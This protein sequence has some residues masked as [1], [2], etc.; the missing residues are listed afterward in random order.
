LSCRCAQAT[1]NPSVG[2]VIS[3]NTWLVPAPGWHPRWRFGVPTP[4]RYRGCC[5]RR[6][7]RCYLAR[8]DRV[9]RPPQF[10]GAPTSRRLTPLGGSE[11]HGG[12]P[13]DSLVSHVGGQESQ[14]MRRCA[15]RR[16]FL[17][18]IVESRKGNGDQVPRDR[19]RLHAKCVTTICSRQGTDRATRRPAHQQTCGPSRTTGSGERVRRARQS[20]G[21]RAVQDPHFQTVRAMRPEGVVTILASLTLPP[22]W[23]KYFMSR[24]VNEPRNSKTEV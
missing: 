22:R 8:H 21:I 5:F 17:S 18:V 23:T 6:W 3:R 19:C 12:V 16:S 14:K 2:G 15:S 11:R 24:A 1:V 4:S 10:P 13:R 20:P 9:L 7:R